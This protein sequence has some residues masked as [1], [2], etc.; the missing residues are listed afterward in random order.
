VRYH[1][2]ETE[3]NLKISASVFVTSRRTC[4]VAVL[5]AACDHE[6]IAVYVNTAV[7]GAMLHNCVPYLCHSNDIK[8]SATV[9]VLYSAWRS[10]GGSRNSGLC[11]F[12]S[13][14]LYGNTSQPPGRGPV[15]GPGIKYNGPREALLEFV[16]LIF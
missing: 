16:N 1:P 9:G 8:L 11:F 12:D 10:I 4:L 5:Q 13:Q 15:V 14:V 2:G 6:A 3:G 7:S